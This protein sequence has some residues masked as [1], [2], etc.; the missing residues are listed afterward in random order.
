MTRGGQAVYAKFLKGTDVLEHEPI[1]CV[2][3]GVLHNL[4][5]VYL[6]SVFLCKL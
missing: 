6:E 1:K 4:T 2:D 3:H 5:E